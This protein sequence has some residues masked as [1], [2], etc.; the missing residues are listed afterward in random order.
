MTL[1]E[2]QNQGLLE[3]AEETAA[4]L[5]HSKGEDDAPPLLARVALVIGA[6]LSGIFLC[7][8]FGLLFDDIFDIP[9]IPFFLGLVVVAGSLVMF[10]KTSGLF[11]EQLALAVNFAGTA[12]FGAG[13]AA[14]ADD[15]IS[16]GDELTCVLIAVAILCPIVFLISKNPVQ[17]FLSLGWVFTIGWI[18]AFEER[19]TPMLIVILTVSL[20]LFLLSWLRP[21]KLFLN[22]STK[23][24]SLASFLVILVAISLSQTW[25][26]RGFL[27]HVYPVVNTLVP[28]SLGGVL[29]WVHRDRDAKSIFACVAFAALL[30]AI[31][32]AGAPGVAFAIGLMVLA[33]IM[34]DR[35][36][37]GLAPILL[38]GFLIF[39]Y[40]F[41][42]VPLLTKSLWLGGIGG[43]LLI[44][45][46][47]LLRVIR[48]RL[49][50]S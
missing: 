32:W 2:L 33:H 48:P 18:V 47:V 17:Q 29:V 15:L 44:T 20:L 45:C 37:A 35:F 5:N 6:W 21:G 10:R 3:S 11:L 12:L 40:Y 16:G 4:A 8:F 31:S 13:T 46:A 9:P 14:W 34:G 42:G 24:A 22:T 41:L 25:S 43:A 49:S 23:F 50:P 1:Q 30:F 28:L 7:L 27:E 39:F 19:S 26:T 36:L 38:G